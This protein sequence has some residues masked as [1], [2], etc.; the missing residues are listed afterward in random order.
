M[1]PSSSC[2]NTFR[3]NFFA[4]FAKIDRRLRS[5]SFGIGP[6][7]LLVAACTSQ[8]SI[9]PHFDA[10]ERIPIHIA[11]IDDQ[12]IAYLDVGTGPPLF[13]I[14]GF[15]GSM[16]QWEHQQRELAR[17]FRV[18]TPDLPGFGLSDKPD[19]EYRPDQLVG[20]FTRF[21]DALHI[22]RATLI[23]NSM[24]AGLAMAV[25]LDHPERVDKLVLIGGLPRDIRAKLTS[26]IVKRTID[27]RTPSWLISLGN[28]LFGGWMVTSV[29]EELVYDR[30]LITPAVLE[31]SNRNRRL[32]GIIKPMLAMKQTLGLWESGYALRLDAIR[33]PTLI[34][35]GEEDRVFPS[36]VGHEL[37][38]LIEGSQ[39]QTIPFAGHIPQ[40]ERPDLV[41]RL[42]I[43]YIHP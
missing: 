8:S 25:A 41:N 6:L 7:L 21:M 23:G 28:R 29:L 31:R 16:W 24:G 14:H 5:G 37:H 33:H 12:R 18:I 26:P 42:L 40:W 1:K 36:S 13:L 35:W 2:N 39:L 10:F 3:P 34:I 38:R 27:T 20:F 32:P 9:P 4:R 15:G 19:I 22:P 30:S 11:T 43:A 17:H